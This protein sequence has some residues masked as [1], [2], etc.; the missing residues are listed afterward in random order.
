MDLIEK[1]E[2][3]DRS[4]GDVHPMGNPHYYMD[5]PRM[6]RVASALA[7]AAGRADPQRPARFTVA[8]PRRSRRAVAARVPRVEAA[9]LPAR[10]GRLLPQ[11]RQLPG[12]AARACRSWATSSRFPASRRPASHLRDL[13]ARLKG[14]RGVIIYATFQPDEG[15][16]FLAKSLGWKVAQLPF[17]VDLDADTAAYLAHIDRWV[18]GHRERERHD[19]PIACST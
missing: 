12:T 13:V 10:P 11:G 17:E 18:D 1:G 16:Q 9:R 19:R 5:P 8:G 2:A 4:R 7:A 3:A 14:T 6:A 15:P